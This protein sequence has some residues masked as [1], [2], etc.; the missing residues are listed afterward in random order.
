[1]PQ[2]S[3]LPCPKAAGIDATKTAAAI[4]APTAIPCLLVMLLSIILGATRARA[5]IPA[6]QCAGM[7]RNAMICV[8]NSRSQRPGEAAESRGEA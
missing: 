8:K 4:K 5:N 1:V 3:W 7:R 2:F 6:Q